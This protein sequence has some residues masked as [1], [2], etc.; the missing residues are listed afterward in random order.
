[1]IYADWSNFSF[2]EMPILGSASSTS[3][4]LNECNVAVP[5]LRSGPFHAE[6]TK[7]LAAH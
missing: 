4:S 6:A 3:A 7:G 2:T 1:M 5:A